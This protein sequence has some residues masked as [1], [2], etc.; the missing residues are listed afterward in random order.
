MIILNRSIHL[1]KTRFFLALLSVGF[2]G[3]AVAAPLYWSGTNTWDNGATV[4]WGTRSG[5]PY[6][7]AWSGGSDAHFQGTAGN[8]TVSGS[9][10]SVNSLNF[11]VSGY[12]LSGGSIN[13]TG[14]GGTV[15]VLSGG[16]ATINSVLTGS[17][18]PTKTG[19]GTLTLT[20]S[21]TYTGGT[22]IGGGALQIGNGGTSG[23][24]GFGP[25][26]DNAALV[27]NLSSGT[28]SNAISG[29]GT[30]SNFG[31]TGALTFA[32]N[33]APAG[34]NFT[35]SSAGVTIAS[36]VNLSVGT[37]V[38][39]IASAT[40]GNGGANITFLGASSLSA[41]G[42]A[43][44][45]ISGQVSTNSGG[46]AGLFLTGATLATAGNINFSGMNNN[47]EWGIGFGGGVSSITA[48]SGTT[49]L[50]GDTVSGGI[51]KSPY[52][53]LSTP[54]VKL[55]ANPGAALVL[56]GGANSG[57][58]ISVFNDYNVGSVFDTSGN[59]S[60]IAA[61]TD[62]TSAFW[63]QEGSY[64]NG[65]GAP[66]FNVASGG[67]LTLNGGVTKMT[68]GLKV[69]SSGALVTIAGSGSG[70]MSGAMAINA[71][72]LVYNILGSGAVT[73]S[74]VVSGTGALAKNGAG[75][76]TLSGANT[77]SGGTTISAGAIVLNN[78]NAVQSSTV[79]LSANSNLLFNSS[80]GAIATFNVG[81]LAG[82]GNITL[83]DGSYPVTL[84]AGGNG[85]ATTYG[86]NISGAGGALNKIG[87]G[88]LTLSG[89]NYI[90]TLTVGGGTVNMP[91][92]SISTPSHGN[93]EDIGA[94]GF[95]QSGGTN[96]PSYFTVGYGGNGTYTLSGSGFL[97]GG[98]EE[99]SSG[100][101]T[102]IFTQS[103][104]TNVTGGISLGSS[105][106]YNL[107]GGFLGLAASPAL[108]SV[109]GAATFNFGGGTL[110]AIAPWTS[111]LNM[112]LTGNSGNGTVDTTGGN[113]SLAG[114][115][116][117]SGGLTK[118]GSGSLTLSGSNTYGGG[119]L[120]VGGVLTAGT[121]NA[122]SPNSDH[123]ITGGTLD[124]SAFPQTVNSLTMTGG[125]LNL[126]VG[127]E[128]TCLG[129]AIFNGTL[130]ISNLGGILSGGTTEL[131]SY[132]FRSGAFRSFTTLPAGYSLVYSSQ[133]LDIVSVAP[134][135][136]TWQAATW[137]GDWNVAGN[138]SGGVVPTAR[139]RMR[140]STTLRARPNRHLPTCPSHWGDSTSPAAIASPLP[141]F[142]A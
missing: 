65:G 26:V 80:G 105:G 37:G 102:G 52:L 126:S 85:A 8:V 40:S 30:V 87:A 89:I 122:L 77:Y 9:I 23:N 125:V 32:Q 114:N 140:S 46:N 101:N 119:T 48:L 10:A 29:S 27:Y 55:S 91:S 124:C 95:T 72:T 42:T 137:L 121:T 75:T 81:G 39:T 93:Y 17:V 18:G 136:P 59:V 20:A 25:I 74:G 7:T 88:T 60:F 57:T 45:N 141:A 62:P 70:T 58:G 117:G 99:I 104:G 116:S 112:N 139:G 107:N 69:N 1:A 11:D 128:L 41:S 78:A 12:T 34:G 64:A 135:P 43:S 47:E 3:T 120:L 110:G 113:I 44:I 118:A 56:L 35:F 111:S 92:G 6:T 66:T 79:T 31:A 24:A 115:L 109:P 28:L 133:S 82:S 16:I 61:T 50:N 5:G 51:S 76:L 63:G 132:V 22:T 96:L 14:S 142:K 97:G 38:G 36:G 13:L 127:N 21:N 19:A 98:E 138:W 130:E 134:G 129:A 67:T 100:A 49:T 2:T 106:T 15:S 94:G 86:G 103:G 54:T 108:F 131:I 4:D 84:S 53:F 33:I 71:G 73:Q 83:A 90:G 123:I 68:T